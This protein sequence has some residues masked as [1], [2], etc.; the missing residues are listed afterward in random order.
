MNGIGLD[1]IKI[2][3]IDKLKNN[4]KFIDKIFDEYE[5]NYI[6][7]KKNNIETVAGFFACKE[8]VSKALGTG[9]GKTSWKDIKIR[10][11]SNGSPYSILKLSDGSETH[12]DLSI[13]HEK[14]YALAVAFL[15]KDE[16]ICD[17]EPPI[18]LKV[19]NKE[20][21][22]GDYG[23]ISIIGGS[24]GMSGSVYLASTAALKMGSGLV[25]SIVPQ[26]I[27][28]ILSIK[29]DEIIVKTINSSKL[30]LENKDYKEIMDKIKGSDAVGIGPGLGW[31]ENQELLVQNLLETIEKPVVLDA[32]GLNCISKNTEILKNK[33]KIIVTPHIGEME[34]LTKKPKEYIIKNP[35]K[36]ALEFSKKYNVVTVLKKSNTVVA[37]PEGEIYINKT[38]N[39][40][41]ATAG[42]G[43]VLTGI[44]TSL[45]GQGYSCF[46]SAKLGVFIHGLAGDMASYKYS[47]YSMTAKDIVEFLPETVKYCKNKS[48]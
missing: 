23:R 16:F 20:S 17:Y 46:D 45:I 22:K 10:H 25:Y 32:D 5:K 34:R 36:T 37:N 11:D 15:D 8:A 4:K 6:E 33:D 41:M 14:E 38:G 13:T 43:D 27:A 44:I 40:G 48:T 19:R 2:S 30:F 7:S 9:I 28:D 3:R 31:N 26:S 39:P 42:S 21:H 47:D 18:Y 35:E 24:Y 1:I 12:V 29:F